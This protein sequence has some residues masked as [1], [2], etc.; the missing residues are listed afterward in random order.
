MSGLEINKKIDLLF[1]EYEKSSSSP[2]LV[3]DGV[4]DPKKWDKSACKI[5]F[6]LKERNL[7]TIQRDKLIK[8]HQEKEI[9]DF[10]LSCQRGHWKVLGQW[11]YALNVLWGAG[12]PIFTE[13]QRQHIEAFHATAI[14]NLKKTAGGAVSNSKIILDEGLAFKKLLARQFDLI[15]Q[16][17]VI[18]GGKGDTYYTAEKILGGHEYGRWV[19]FYHPSCRKSHEFLFDKLVSLYDTGSGT[20]VTRRAHS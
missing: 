13:A 16:D 12:V 14:L 20:E 6:L 17:V 1:D 7:N 10:R 15:R 18:C 8:D 9:Y 4:I 19:D 3:R 5:V 11:A 2:R